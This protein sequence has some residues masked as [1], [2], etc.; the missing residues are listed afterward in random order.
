MKKGLFIVFEGGEGSGKT[1]QA[2]LLYDYYLESGRDV[3]LTKEPGGDESICRDVRKILLNSEY[4]DIMSFR[5]EFLLFEAD[6]AQHVEKIIRPAIQ[7]GRT[8]ISDRF[9]AA[10][11]AYQCGARKVSSL[12][13]FKI[14]NGFATDG[15]KPDFTFWI[16]IDPKVG[17]KRNVDINKRDRFEMEDIGFHNEVRNGYVTYFQELANQESWIKLDGAKTIQDL[18]REIIETLKTKR[19]I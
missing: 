10:T 11:F 7:L 16:D 17:L 9:D 19:L 14:T 5:A 4:K 15:L 1:T 13:N 12:E 8:V 18:H 3:L 6:R 2:K